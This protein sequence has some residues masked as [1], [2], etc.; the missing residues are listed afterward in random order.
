VPTPSL[1][2]PLGERQVGGLGLHLVR[3]LMDRLE[4]KRDGAKNLLTLRKRIR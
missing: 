1:D 4:Y 2:A 3:S